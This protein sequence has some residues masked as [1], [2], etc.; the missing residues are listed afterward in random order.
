MSILG[1]P[2]VLAVDQ[3]IGTCKSP[4]LEKYMRMGKGEPASKLELPLGETA[5]LVH[6]TVKFEEYDNN[7][8]GIDGDSSASNVVNSLKDNPKAA[9]ASLEE[10]IIGTVVVEVLRG[11]RLREISQVW[12]FTGDKQDP[13]VSVCP[14]WDDSK[15]MSTN[16]SSNGGSEPKWNGPDNLLEFEY[17]SSKHRKEKLRLDFVV[18]DDKA[19]EDDDELIGSGELDWK[20]MYEVVKGYAREGLEIRLLD[21]TGEDAGS[22]FVNLSFRRMQP[23]KQEKGTPKVATN[24]NVDSKNDSDQNNSEKKAGLVT[25]Q[26]QKATGLPSSW[27][28]TTDP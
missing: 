25:I 8:R 23:I 7:D 24:E 5:G 9:P 6:L 10:K 14:Q 2:V 27:M 17:D 21:E 1:P 4:N 12:G 22:I 19:G 15:E 11:S 16:P 3:K 20:L 18:E 13:L 28:D 26:I